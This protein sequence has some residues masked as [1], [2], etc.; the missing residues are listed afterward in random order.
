MMVRRP[1]ALKKEPYSTAVL[2]PPT[3]TIVAEGS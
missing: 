3:M 2:L 1:V